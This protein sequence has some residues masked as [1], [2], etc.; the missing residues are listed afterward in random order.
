MQHQKQIRAL[1]TVVL[2][3]GVWGCDTERVPGDEADLGAGDTGTLEPDRGPHPDA[4]PPPDAR[5]PRPDAQQTPDQ[6]SGPC[7]K[8]VSKPFKYQPGKTYWGRKNYIEYVAGDLPIIISSPHGGYLKPSEIPN[9]TWGVLGL[10]TGS[11]EK[12]LETA[13]YLKQFTGRR[14]HLIINRLARIKLDA[15]REIKEACQGDKWSEQAWTEYHQFITAAR[16]WVTKRCGKGHY[17][18]FH[19]NGHSAQWVEMGF[20]LTAT[21]LNR[22]DTALNG[23][24]YIN[25]SSIRALALA[26]GSNFAE[27]VR[28]PSSLAGLLMSRGYKAVP[29]PKHPHPAGQGFFSGGYNTRRHG[30][31][32]SGVVDGT[33][34][35]TY[36]KFINNE[37][38]RDDYSRKLAQSLRAF[39]E[40][41]YQFNLKDHAWTPPAHERC[42]HARLLKFT[43]GKVTVSGSTTG[44]S[45]EFGTGVSCGNSFA[46]DG[47]QVYY[48]VQLQGG[49]SYE[50]TLEPD[51]AARFYLFGDTCTPSLITEQCTSSGIAG[52]LVDPHSTK[53]VKVKAPQS[54]IHTVAV[55]S[56][57]N[58]WH[59][60]FTLSI[61]QL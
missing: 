2:L 19:T 52:P 40:L 47:P 24:S 32:T 7:S 49:K 27:I 3:L 29:S 57:A 38:G 33:Q 9:R 8:P 51:F 50:L 36:S 13:N 26:P 58:A 53:S 20:L 25:K 30:S 42:V 1:A 21:D 59:G 61:K 48:K 14:P 23:A 60:S 18:D 22:S 12:T 37:A 54:G 41:H 39:M 28:G 17:F 43:G 4:G 6:A 46:L 15:N 55:D 31:R 5:L 35:E 44:A 56:R 10:D 16:D 45:N 11:Q 34:V